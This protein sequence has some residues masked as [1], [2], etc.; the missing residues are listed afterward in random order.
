MTENK[1]IIDEIDVSKCKDFH[2]GECLNTAETVSACEN[3]PSCLFKQLHRYKQVVKEIKNIAKQ[4]V[5]YINLD[6][7]KTCTEVEYD[8][9]G[10]IWNLEQRMYN[11]LQKIAECEVLNDR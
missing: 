4:Q 7:V 11:I 10:K 1:P 6:Q 2:Y 9:A 5:P 8:Y 3:C